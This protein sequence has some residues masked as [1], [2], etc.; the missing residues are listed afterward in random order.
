MLLRKAEG[1][2]EVVRALIDNPSIT[3]DAIGFHA[4][5]AVEKAL[6]PSSRSPAFAFLVRTTSASCWNWPTAAACEFPTSCSTRAG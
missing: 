5:Q 2:V 1:D 4:Q 3:D 6:K